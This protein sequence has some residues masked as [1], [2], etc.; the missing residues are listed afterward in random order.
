MACQVAVDFGDAWITAGGINA[1]IGGKLAQIETGAKAA[2]RT[3][4]PAFHTASLT[5]AC[6]LRPGEG[7]NSER[8]INE[9][10]AVVASALHFSYEV[11]KSRGR[12]ADA[13]PRLFRHLRN[14]YLK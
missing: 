13:I 10:G 2:G 7:L 8:V 12:T 1:R 5:T 4:P 9:T 11:C 3:L 6:V 14:D